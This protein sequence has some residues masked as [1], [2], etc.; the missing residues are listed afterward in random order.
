MKTLIHYLL[1]ICLS[2]LISISLANASNKTQNSHY[3]GTLEAIKTP[4]I[5]T[6]PYYD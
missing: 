5:V 4:I 3:S 1:W 6:N 2:S